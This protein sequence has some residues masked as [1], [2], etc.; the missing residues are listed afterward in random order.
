MAIDIK[1][2]TKLRAQTGAGMKDCREALEESNGDLEKAVEILRKKGAKIAIKRA[3]KEAKEGIVYAYIHANKKIGALVELNCETDFVAKNE[4]FKNLAH[5]LA[6]QI[7]A[8]NPLYISPADVPE[9]VL[10]KEKEIIKEQL[11]A[12]GKPEKMLAKIIEGKLD[13]WYEEICLSKQAFIKNEDITIED[14]INEKIASLGEKIKVG[15]F[16]RKQI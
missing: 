6:L 1:L 10:N 14:L 12:E 3:D 2:I 11:L 9:E 15:G 16:C 7:A 5:D 13:K 8:Q 4:E